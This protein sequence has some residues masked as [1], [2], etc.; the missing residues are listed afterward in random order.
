M[1]T[2]AAFAFAFLGA[3]CAVTVVIGLPGTWMLIALA[4]VVE[5]FDHHWLGG[6]GQVTFG[7]WL[8]GGTAALALVGEGLEIAAGALGAK[9]GGGSKKGALGAVI[10]GMLGGLVGTFALPIPVVGTLV[11]ALGGTFGGAL[12]GELRAAEQSGQSR[13]LSTAIRPALGATLGRVLGTVAKTGI[14]GIAW[15]TLTVAAFIA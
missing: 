7:W 5:I 8:I 2:T 9:G 11:G 13:E 10:G 6:A 15:L 3:L 4:V 1:L 14:A 12:W